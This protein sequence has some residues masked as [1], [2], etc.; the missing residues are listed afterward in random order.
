MNPQILE[1]LALDRALGQLSADVVSL[2]DDYLATHAES[3][4]MD[5]A[6]RETVQ[7]AVAILNKPGKITETPPRKTASLWRGRARDAAALAAAFVL[8]ATLV[9]ALPH[10]KTASNRAIQEEVVDREAVPA[11]ENPPSEIERQARTLPFWSAQRAYLL[12]SARN[13]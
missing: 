3:S 12:S 4:R 8:G 2:L 13:K 1:R 7:L 10:L 9:V 5:N 11:H 6:Y